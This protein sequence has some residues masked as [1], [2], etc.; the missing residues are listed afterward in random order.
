MKEGGL[1][2]PDIFAF[3]HHTKINC[4]KNLIIEYNKFLIYISHC[5]GLK[6][7]ARS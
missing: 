2:M 1:R 6:K 5:V 7:A 3:S 4:V